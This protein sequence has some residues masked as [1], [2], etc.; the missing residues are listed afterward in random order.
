M[1]QGKHFDPKYIHH[2]MFLFLIQLI[3]ITDYGTLIAGVLRRGK[4]AAMAYFRVIFRHLLA[5]TERNHQSRYPIRGQNFDLAHAGRKFYRCANLFGVRI[6][7][8]SYSS[9]VGVSVY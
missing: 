3:Y 6:S 4:K 7:S 8:C 2:S 9:A 5:G 1:H